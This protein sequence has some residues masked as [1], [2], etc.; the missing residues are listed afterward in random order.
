MDTFLFWCNTW[1]GMSNEEK[2]LIEWEMK[3]PL[4]EIIS[5]TEA[6]QPP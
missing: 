3:V 1:E 2:D 5:L 4:N 6:L